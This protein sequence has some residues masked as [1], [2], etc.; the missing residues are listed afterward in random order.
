MLHQM[1]DIGD[2]RQDVCLFLPDTWKTMQEHKLGMIH[3]RYVV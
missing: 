2:G 1:K 3:F